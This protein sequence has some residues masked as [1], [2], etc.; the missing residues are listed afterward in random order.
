MDKAEPTYNLA[1]I[2]AQMYCVAQTYMRDRVRDDLKE[3]G[4][5]K[6]QLVAIIQSL[7]DNEFRKSMESVINP[8]TWQD[9]YQPQY[10]EQKLYL[11]FGKAPDGDEYIVVSCHP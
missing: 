11:K 3:L 9:A 5:T 6:V 10:G 8:G 1:D 7:T 4:I 2:K